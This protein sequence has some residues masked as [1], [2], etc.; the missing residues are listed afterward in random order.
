MHVR[1]YLRD[2]IGDTF[3]DLSPRNGVLFVAWHRFT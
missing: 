1:P 3:A 2:G